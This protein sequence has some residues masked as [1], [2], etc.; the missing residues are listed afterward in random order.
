MLK[1]SLGKGHLQKETMQL[2]QQA[3]SLGK[4][5]FALHVVNLVQFPATGGSK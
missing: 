1:Y 4:K 5:D 3:G 2:L